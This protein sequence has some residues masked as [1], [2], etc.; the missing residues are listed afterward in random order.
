MRW[1]TLGLG[2]C[3]LIACGSDISVNES[4]EAVCNGVLDE[5][6]TRVDGPFDGDKDGYFD[7]DNPGCVETY[8]P[9]DL[10][11][12]DSDSDVWGPS[13][14]YPDEDG[15]GFG[16][17][18]ETLLSCEL[19]LGFSG[20]AD[21]CDD[22]LAS[23]YPGAD[24]YCDEVDNDC[25]DVIDEDVVDGLVYYRD[26]DGDGY[27]SEDAT[28]EACTLPDGYSASMGDC[29]DAD[30]SLNPDEAEECFDGDDNN[31]DGEI[32]EGCDV[33]LSGS[34]TADTEI[35]YSCGAGLVTIAFD[36]LSV[37]EDEPVIS[38]S[39]IGSSRP[40]TMTGTINPDG[41]AVS[42]AS[43]FPGICTE[44]YTLTGT[45][46]D[47]A[48]FEGTFQASYSGGSCGDC[49]PQVWPIILTR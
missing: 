40:G 15:D 18:G 1:P 11:C 6:E 8:P 21:D 4:G 3:T 33:N 34:W 28:L 23:I 36:T 49:G 27:G 47:D 39:S 9:E 2:L 37:I 24:E 14:W 25:D 7:G 45:F 30:A 29:D 32:D 19:A 38:F 17:D 46:L 10:D 42:A 44:T 22:S 41:W 48:S 43:S 26:A 5:D 16:V 31:C 20:N 35:I 12:D 13:V